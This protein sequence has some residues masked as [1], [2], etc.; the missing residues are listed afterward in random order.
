MYWKSG[1]LGGLVCLALYLTPGLSQPNGPPKPRVLDEITVDGPAIFY[2]IDQDVRRELWS[3]DCRQPLRGCVARAPGL[4]LRVDEHQQPWLVAA[5]QHGART[6]VQVVNFTQDAPFLLSRP[7]DAGMLDQLTRSNAF[8]VI[9]E[10]GFVAQRTRSTGIAHVA[11]YLAWLNTETAR[12]LRDARLWPSHGRLA[13]GDMTPEVLERYE[14][15][16]RRALEA[17]RQLVPATKPQVEFAM[18]AQNGQSF[19]SATGRMED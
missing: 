7:L 14:V 5:A 8:V 11:N 1:I 4:V 17:H 13:V 9:E 3:V 2:E 12:T 19:F 18:R 15:M 16:Q 10:S 6:S